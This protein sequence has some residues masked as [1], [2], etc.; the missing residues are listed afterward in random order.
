MVAQ[1]PV[2]ADYSGIHLADLLDS[3][4][5]SIDKGVVSK[6]QL[7]LREIVEPYAFPVV[8]VEDFF[9]AQMKADLEEVGYKVSSY[10]HTSFTVAEL[11]KD[12]SVP[13]YEL[14]YKA[15]T[16]A[17]PYRQWALDDRALSIA[18]NEKAI[19]LP[20]HFDKAFV[21]SIRASNERI[22]GAE[23]LVIEAIKI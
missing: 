18:L 15:V 17:R 8:V 5:D 10:Y 7:F 16:D 22:L 19:A 13:K 14:I 6:L 21:D 12:W 3:E 2:T 23:I 4:R 9:V 20:L 11:P 1:T